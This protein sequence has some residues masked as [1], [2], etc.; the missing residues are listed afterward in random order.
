MTTP[1]SD[2]GIQTVDNGTP[3]ARQENVLQLQDFLAICRRKWWWI[4][5]SLVVCLGASWVYYKCQIPVY[6]REALVLVVRSDGSRGSDFGSVFQQMGFFQQDPEK[7]T[8]VIA[9]TA[10]SVIMEVVKRLNLNVSYTRPKMWHPQVLYGTNQ[11]VVVSFPGVP[12]DA[13]IQL[14]LQLEPDGTGIITRIKRTLKGEK[15]NFKD[16]DIAFNY[17]SGSTVKTPIGQVEIKPN[18]VY[19]GAKLA[20]TEEI[21]VHRMSVYSRTM[22]LSS[23]LSGETID[24]WADIL[25]LKLTDQSTQRAEDII[26]MLVSV[27]NEDGVRERS[28]IAEATSRFINDRLNII[29]QELGNVDSDIATFK[30]A[31]LLPD[32]GASA[33]M[34][35]NNANKAAETLIDLTNRLAMTRYLRDF[36][37][38]S[39]NEN[40]VLP[41]NTGVA[42]V[43]I[44]SQ[45]ADY[46]KILLE[47]NSLVANSSTSNPLVAELDSRLR[48]YRGALV[49]NLDNA[50]TSLN[51]SI[52]AFKREEASNTSKIA[53][54]PSQ[55]RYLLSVERQQKVKESLYLYLLQKREENELAQN[56]ITNKIRVVSPPLGSTSPISPRRNLI[57]LV[58]FVLGILIPVTI[59]YLREM[60]NTTVRD[61][62]DID[63][64]KAP[65]VGE[66]PLNRKPAGML[67]RILPRKEERQGIVVRPENRD[68]INEA[69]RVLR[70][71]LHL[72][73]RH[74]PGEPAAVI[75]VTSASPGS[76]KTFVSTNL[77]AALAIK[78]Q[79]IL[80]MD[81]DLRRTTL[82]KDILGSR[83]STTGG[84]VNYLVGTASPDQIICHD[85][86]GIKGLDLIPVGPVPP[87]P[88]EL[89]E[90]P[91]M[92]EL[93]AQLR[94]EYDV[95]ILD[96][97]P[98]DIVAD[99]MI[100][101][102]LSDLTLFV[103]R[104]GL[105]QRSMLPMI[106]EIYDTRRYGNMAIV[107]NATAEPVAGYGYHYSYGYGYGDNLHK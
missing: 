74:K 50:I 69:F 66:L 12:D 33:T 32:V 10:P 94:N 17:I 53:S 15:E 82:S 58:G 45:I 105:F 87:N 3:S 77:A 23:R 56:Y 73:L 89:L 9:L 78:G 27:Y 107:L 81:L 42:D 16:L 28:R 34:Y 24:D 52:A 101:N 30:S 61:R 84:L 25:T 75:S 19:S 95:I 41:S 55:A 29:E 71:S 1:N 88:S 98:I 20:E 104:A 86:Q 103:I 44:E 65:F 62:K 99:T 85:V 13:V 39:K 63:R 14:D 70:T 22:A 90:E 43:N 96:C 36:M 80:L 59:L 51:T 11:P 67:E 64:L 68:M 97:P 49:Q 35:V 46:N 83:A 5:I 4:V 54:T 37:T 106:Q 26:N 60:L 18:P 100:V 7:N 2:E 76:G 57:L 40:S 79:R 21:R 31:N 93:V 38:S 91:R 92:K 102:P 47:R 8:E 6:E 72:M 48:S